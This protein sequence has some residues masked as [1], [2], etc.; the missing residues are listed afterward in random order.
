MNSK[1]FIDQGS[2]YLAEKDFHYLIAS[3]T[4]LKSRVVLLTK[5][6]NVIS[7]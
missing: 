5:E 2:T 7:K 1:C 6:E 3:S 4:D